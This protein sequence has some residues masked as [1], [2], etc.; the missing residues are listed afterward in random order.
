MHIDKHTSWRDFYYASSYYDPITDPE[1]KLNYQIGKKF[2]L[3]V[4]LVGGTKYYMES[5]FG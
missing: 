5:S 1:G 4:R 2:S 3:W